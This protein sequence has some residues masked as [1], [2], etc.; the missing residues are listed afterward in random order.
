MHSQLPVVAKIHGDPALASAPIYYWQARYFSAE[1]YSSG[2]AQTLT[3]PAQLAAAIDSGQLFTLV[4]A[5][6]QIGSLPENL[7]TRLSE[8]QS[9]EDFAVYVPITTGG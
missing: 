6:K 5:R 3:E 4:V 8:V 9:V 2:V 7:R 1:Y